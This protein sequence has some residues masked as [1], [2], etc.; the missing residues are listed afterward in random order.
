MT[1]DQTPGSSMDTMPRTRWGRAK[2]AGGRLSAL[3]TAVPLGVALAAGIA[4]IA[5][6]TG[7]AGP[8][9]VA[10]AVAIGLITVWPCFGLAWALVVDRDTLRGAPADPEQSVESAWYQR[11]ASGAFTDML[12]ITGLGTAAISFAAIDIPTH[13]ALAAVLIVA[14][15]SFAVRYAIQHRQG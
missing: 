4:A 7:G 1:D 9:P 10:G 8:R 12:L 2:F 3:W 14:M 15:G 13:L 11:A 6:L 5:V